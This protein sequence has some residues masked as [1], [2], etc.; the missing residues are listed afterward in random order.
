MT[1]R[2]ALDIPTPDAGRHHSPHIADAIS[3]NV[4]FVTTSSQHTSSRPEG[5]VNGRHKVRA[6]INKFNPDPAYDP[7]LD[8]NA[9]GGITL[10]DVMMYIPVFN[11]TC[12]P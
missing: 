3:S 8:L 6:K 1:V 9:S 11:L 5:R 2:E 7:R 12:T 10:E 4:F